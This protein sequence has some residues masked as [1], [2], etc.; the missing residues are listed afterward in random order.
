MAGSKRLVIIPRSCFR[1]THKGD[2]KSQATDAVYAS[3]AQ[4]EREGGW[5]LL[6]GQQEGNEVLE[7][8]LAQAIIGRHRS[9]RE[10]LHNISIGI[11]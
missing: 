4:T 7:L 11:Q 3:V 10:T 1:E 6:Q 5:G 2:V 9:L 8:L